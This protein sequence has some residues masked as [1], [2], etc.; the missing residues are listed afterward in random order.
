MK[1]TKPTFGTRRTTTMRIDK[2]RPAAQP[3]WYK[4]LRRLSRLASATFKIKR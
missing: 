1:P 4:N 3:G 2:I